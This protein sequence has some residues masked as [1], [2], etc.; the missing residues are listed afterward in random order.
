MFRVIIFFVGVLL[1]VKIAVS[2]RYPNK[3]LLNEITV[4][5]LE[6]VYKCK[7]GTS[8]NEFGNVDIGHLYEAYTTDWFFLGAKPKGSN[9]I[10]VGAFIPVSH[11]RYNLSTFVT[12]FIY[13]Y[14]APNAFGYAP[15]KDVYLNYADL[16]DPQDPSRYSISHRTDG[17]GMVRLRAGA[18]CN[19]LSNYNDVVYRCSV[20]PTAPPTPKP[21]VPPTPSPTHEPTWPP[22]PPPTHKPTWPPSP[23]PT[24]KPTP[25]P[26]NCPTRKPSKKRCKPTKKP[27]SRCAPHRNSK[28]LNNLPDGDDMVDTREEDLYDEASMEGRL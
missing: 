27:I 10:S 24:H 3:I 26:T 8:Y 22:S 11:I 15:N 2:D 4:D 19:N 17:S 16:R 13:W 28:G 7:D 12:P 25:L 5:D 9:L 21:S 14:N 23:P 6:K 18:L 1:Y 20:I